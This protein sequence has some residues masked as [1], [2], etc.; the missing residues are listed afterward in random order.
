M[1][2]RVCAELEVQLTIMAIERPDFPAGLAAGAGLDLESTTCVLAFNDQVALGVL[3]A[4]RARGI[5]VPGRISVIGCDDSLPD[6]LAWP[7]LTTVDSSSRALG[8]LA[9]AAV[10]E[11]ESQQVGSVPTR[12]IVRRSTAA[13]VLSV[14]PV[15]ERNPREP[16]T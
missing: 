3:A 6:G 8:A 15:P 7:A 2:T 4:L 5:E 10:L 1:L 16:Q 11:P 9:A 14:L 12:L 13:A